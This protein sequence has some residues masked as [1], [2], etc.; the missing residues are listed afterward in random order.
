MKEPYDRALF[1]MYSSLFHN[2]PDACYAIN[3][4]GEFILFNASAVE[5]TGYSTLEAFS[6]T[7]VPWIASE[8]LDDTLDFFSKVLKGEK[9]SHETSILHK[10]GHRIEVAV[11]AVPILMDGKIE[12]IIGMVKNIN[13]EKKMQHLLDGQNS[14]LEMIAKGSS[15]E[16]VLAAIILLIE[17]VSNGGICSIMLLDENSN[18]LVQGASPHLPEEYNAGL[19]KIPVGYGFGSCGTSA[20]FKKPIIVSDISVDPLWANYNHIALKYG[21]KACWSY[22]VLTNNRK[23]LGTFAVYYKQER[24]PA[25]PDIQ[26]VEKATYLASLAIQHYRSKELIHYMAFHDPLTSLPNRRLFEKKAA[27]TI[28]AWRP[29]KALV[30]IMYLDLDRFKII[31]DS[32]GHNIGDALLKDVALRLQKC[33]SNGD[34]SSRQGGDEFTI[35][36]KEVSRY[37]ARQ[38]AKKVLS[39]LSKPFQV[40][41][42]EVFITPS[43]GVSLY[44]HDGNTADELIKKADIAM[45]QAKKQGRNVYQFYEPEFDMMTIERL[46]METALRK[47]M[48]RNEFVLYYQPITSL[49][50]L[51]IIEVEALIRWIHPE[52]GKVPPE[53]FIPIAE[54]TGMIVSIGEWV[55]RTACTQ[56]KAWERKGMPPVSV[57][58]NLSILQFHQAN[59]V[60]MIQDILNETGVKPQYLTIEIT[61][62]MTMDT[63][64]ATRILQLLKEVGVRISIDDFG[65]GY[66]SLSYLRNLPIDYLKI[67][68]SFIGDIH[69]DK[70]G[71][72]IVK[73][74]LLMAQNLGLKA[75]AEGVETVGQV[76]FLQ[77]QKCHAAQ[78][79]LFSMPKAPEE[80]LK[81]WMEKE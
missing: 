51:E 43:I 26:V 64:S 35:L 8:N 67:D 68:Q 24:V 3:P 29:G 62:S 12:G 56:L 78:G 80:F 76:Q 27:E 52:H 60:G 44:P 61:E 47:A 14:I 57:S 33:M 81:Y 69:K 53:K 75:I 37:E 38:T 32:L 70:N 9:L 2:H 54:E 73:T 42:H 59:L 34:I 7:F 17:S 1:E 13:E 36:L 72:S 46:K 19:E 55:I 66:S 65:T 31:N 40:E 58:V 22:P 77:E 74:I 50:S 28:T 45:Y 21:F 30:S 10:D 25:E 20:Y 23:V 39:F 18:C 4:K 63:E 71:E 79:Y 41:G 5:L 6:T 48:E 15:F 16:E 49:D 11:T